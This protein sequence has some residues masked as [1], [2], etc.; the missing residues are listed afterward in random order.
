VGKG[1]GRIHDDGHEDGLP[2]R[3]GCG[4]NERSWLRW[5]FCIPMFCRSDG[6]G[7]RETSGAA[8]ERVAYLVGRFYLHRVRPG[9]LASTRWAGWRYSSTSLACCSSLHLVWWRPD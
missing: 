7:E 4:L 8:R 9:A 3:H 1:T 6:G 2:H 5:L